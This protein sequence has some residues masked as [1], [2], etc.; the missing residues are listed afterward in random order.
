MT[1]GRR[2]LVAAGHSGREGGAEAHVLSSAEVLADAG[3]E[4]TLVVGSESYVDGSMADGAGKIEVRILEGFGKAR[5]E[6]DRRS[7]F[8]DLLA[9]VRPSV[10][11][12]HDDFD[13]RLPPE[14]RRTS[15]VAWSMHNFAGCTSGYK[16]FRRAGDECGRPHGPGCVPHLLFH[17]CAHRRNPRPIPEMYRRTTAR[18]RS[19]RAVD[20]AVAHSRFIAQHLRTNGLERV[21]LVPLFL[22]EAAHPAP[23][24]A[25]PRVLFVGRV[26]PAKGLDVLIRAVA[27][28]D[29]PLDVCGEGWGL[30]RARKLAGKL[31]VEDRI[32]F[33]GRVPPSEISDHYARSS[34]VAVPSLWPE[35]FGLVGLE[36]MARGRP[37]VASATGGIPEWLG[38]GETGLLVPAGDPEAMAGAVAELVRDPARCERMGRG[39]ADRVRG[40]FSRERYLT[41]VREA[42]DAARSHWASRR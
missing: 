21:H 33:H 35:P 25:E 18:M 31:D 4:V 19:L 11:H 13:P 2:I 6:E 17:G 15:P 37:V 20:V 8:L 28:L 39:G 27:L 41:A 16:Y 14:A 38:D 34:I 22:P 32:T 29:M 3:F 7:A 30:A 12:F 9:D 42:Y 40:E 24:P 10:V 5:V 36:A 26:T 1:A 23:P